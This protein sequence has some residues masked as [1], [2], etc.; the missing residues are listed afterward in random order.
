MWA[1]EP[2]GVVDS[3]SSDASA[4]DEE[5][6]SGVSESA[7]RAD[8]PPLA[9]LLSCVVAVL[10]GWSVV[11]S[12]GAGLEPVVV[13]ELVTVTVTGVPGPAVKVFEGLYRV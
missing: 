12:V 6:V 3:V 13:L 10:V 9:V 2:A 5:S 7:G 8:V 11:F 1:R 4:A